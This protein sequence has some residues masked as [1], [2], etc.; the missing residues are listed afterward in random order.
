MRNCGITKNVVCRCSCRYTQWRSQPR[1]WG[2][3]KMFDFRRITL[4]CLEKQLS[5][6]KMSIFSKYLGGHGLLGNAYGCMVYH[7]EKNNQLD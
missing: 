1:N 4:F 3:G 2:G 7:T 6:H 5:K